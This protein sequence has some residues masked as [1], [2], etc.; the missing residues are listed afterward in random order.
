MP[1]KNKIIVADDHP[2]LL[3]GL[4]EELI[5]NN[6]NV[7]AT[8]EDGKK[9][10][11]LI[12]KHKPDIAILDI[13]MPLLSGFDVIKKCENKNIN[14][15]FIVLT[16]HKENRYVLKAKT[17]NISGYL[18]KDEP[19]NEIEKCIEAIHNGDTYFSSEFNAV[20][21]NQISPE[22]EKLQTLSPSEIKILQLISQDKS[23]KDI[24]ESLFI[25]VRTVQ[26]HRT[27]IIAKLNTNNLLDWTK[28]NKEL[29]FLES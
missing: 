13:Q 16:S 29:V 28:V 26:K 27:N 20:Y 19:F 14:T 8:A 7:I 1:K 17:L 11:A 6:Y 4:T 23:T 9:A 12:L 21:E 24:A 25:S 22:L 18:L 10:L 5:S 3:K 15:K 2:L